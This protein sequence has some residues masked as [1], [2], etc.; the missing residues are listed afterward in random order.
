MCNVN[1]TNPPAFYIHGTLHKV[2]ITGTK[3]LVMEQNIM[4]VISNVHSNY[5]II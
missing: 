3:N 4:A 2:S 5:Y 1:V